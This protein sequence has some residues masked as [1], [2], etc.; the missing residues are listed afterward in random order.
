MCFVCVWLFLVFFF[1]FFTT[2]EPRVLDIDFSGPPGIFP[3][4]QTRSLPA[5]RSASC[6]TLHQRSGQVEPNRPHQYFIE[7]LTLSSSFPTQ[8]QQLC[9]L[10]GSFDRP[11]WSC[12]S[13]LGR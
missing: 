8:Q 3:P 4:F 12:S 1:S 13:A 5:K 9:C 7:T 10:A 2:I 6:L 11:F